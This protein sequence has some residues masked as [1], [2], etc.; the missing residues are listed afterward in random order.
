MMTS[1]PSA[2]AK[3][4]L[5]LHVGS[6]RA[7]GYHP[8]ES[9][10]AFADC[11]DD[12][13]FSPGG[14]AFSIQVSGPFAKAAG[15]PEQNLVLKAARAL[16]KKL[17]GIGG[18]KFSLTKNLPAGA[19]LGGGSSDAAAA[20]RLIAKENS[21]AL[22]DPA[23]YEAALACGADVPVCLERKA[24]LISGIGEVLSA[25]VSIP[26]LHAVLVWPATHV[27]TPAVYRAFDEAE[28]PRSTEFGIKASEIPLEQNAFVKFLKKQNND[29][30]RAAWRVT[31]HV[32]EAEATLRAV[33]HT[34]LIR[35]SGSGSALFA[36][37]EA[38][39]DAETEAAAVSARYPDWWVKATTLR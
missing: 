16:K 37:Y 36:I 19:G 28:I 24:R 9:L 29:L 14:D 11:G 17:P 35:I 2:P 10:V 6:A 4:N 30:T 23:L 3:I 38:A 34:R 18:G 31:P 1:R 13:Q 25:P 39:S 12:L 33:D 8:I 20:L 26:V 5:F 27:S 32:A 15:D 7:D 22:N 21:V